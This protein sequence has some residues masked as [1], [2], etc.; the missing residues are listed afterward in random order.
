MS[1]ITDKG[2]AQRAA[3]V[4]ASDLSLY[5]EDD[6]VAGIVQDDLFERLADEIDKG[7]EHY[8]S[9]VAAELVD[10]EKEARRLRQRELQRR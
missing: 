10:N 7:R 6:V 9:R 2:R 3:R 1:K 5:H 8:R 4:I